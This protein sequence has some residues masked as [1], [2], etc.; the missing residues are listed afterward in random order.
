MKPLTKE[1]MKQ[2]VHQ[3]ESAGPFLERLRWERLRQ[4]QYDWREVDALL[5]MADRFGRSRP[6]SGLIEMQRLF[7]LLA[8][9]MGLTSDQG[10][11]GVAGRCS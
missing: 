2:V 9:R 8:V 5:G 1:Q 11:P 6:T 7:K 3:W 10:T 4:W